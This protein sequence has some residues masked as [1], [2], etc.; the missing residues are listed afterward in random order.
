MLTILFT[1]NE[2]NSKGIMLVGDDGTIHRHVQEGIPCSIIPVYDRA[3]IVINEEFHEIC[4]DPAIIEMA[5]FFVMTYKAAMRAL[6]GCYNPNPEGEDIWENAA[7]NNC[8]KE[9]YEQV[10]VARPDAFV[11]RAR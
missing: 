4:M 2:L 8:P 1:D 11:G 10:L 3:F 7:R 5:Q 6:S 9:F